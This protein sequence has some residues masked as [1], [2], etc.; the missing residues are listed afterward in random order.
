MVETVGGALGRLLGILDSADTE[1][2]KA[3]IKNQEL[4]IEKTNQRFEHEQ[5]LLEASGRSTEAI[6]RKKLQAQA[7]NIKK[8]IGNLIRLQQANGELTTDEQKNLDDLKESLRKNYEDR[9]V[10]DAK[11]LK[12]QEDL[13]KEISSLSIVT[14][15]QIGRA[16]V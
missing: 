2:A 12:S 3:A 4:I 7:D 6:E 9:A 15:K 10:L 8:Q 5:K 13:G 11:Y 1:K 14:G 16:H